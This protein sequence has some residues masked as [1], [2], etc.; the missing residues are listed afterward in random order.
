MFKRFQ[1]KLVFLFTTLFMIIQAMT[2]FS[3]YFATKGNLEEQANQQLLYSGDVFTQTVKV[4]TEKWVSEASIYSTDYGFRSAVTT[5]DQA[6]V[7]SALKNLSSRI[8]VDRA[9]LISMDN[10]VIAELSEGGAVAAPTKLFDE[11]IEMADEYG[12]ATA[13]LTVNDKIYQYTVVPVL[14]PI[15]VAWVAMGTLIDQNKLAEFK[16]MLPTGVDITF[17]EQTDEGGVRYLETTLDNEIMQRINELSKSEQIASSEPRIINLENYQLMTRSGELPSD[18]ENSPIKV[19][20][21][22]SLDV[23][24][25]PYEPLA[26]V[27]I[28]LLGLGLFLL[29]VGSV[30]VAKS[31]SKPLNSLVSIVEEISRDKNYDKRVKSD[32]ASGEIHQL[33]ISFNEMLDT[34]Q[35]HERELISSKEAAEAASRTKSQF[36]ANMSHELRTPLNAII[37]FSELI[38]PSSPIK[39]DKEKSQE[40]AND[41]NMSAVHLLQ[42]IND[43]LDLSRIEADKHELFEEIVGL[44]EVVYSCDRL[45]R[46]KAEEAGL[47][48]IN[49]VDDRSISMNVDER[50]FKQIMINLLSNA[51]KFTPSGGTIKMDAA[52]RDDGSLEVIVHDTGIGMAIDD[53]P[54][55]LAPFG[56]IDAGLNRKF[57]GT[58]LGLPLVKKLL[59]MQG[60]ELVLNSKLGQG[61]KAIV[62]L[63]AVRIFRDQEDAEKAA[64]KSAESA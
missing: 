59:E 6:T 10:E 34:I 56:Q 1:T 9:L 14:A 19:L 44:S 20:Q 50:T 53:I 51:V 32:Q 33:Y 36:L 5:D 11:L 23:A 35:S 15:P 16:K 18:L 52:I 45:I 26:Y 40:Y 46:T 43:I 48:L 47:T 62:I 39:L 64:T 24:Y 17:Y 37:G 30:T 41:I 60:S 42:V 13:F 8:G 29:F 25:G 4:N 63:P 58:G 38:G 28:M 49:N 27:L 54:K 61:T 2:Y 7:L 3:V 22:Y 21:T 55:A 31:V 57:E 12:D